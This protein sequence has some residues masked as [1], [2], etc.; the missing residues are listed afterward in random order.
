MYKSPLNYVGNKYRLLPQLLKLFPKNINNFIDLFSGGCDVTINTSAKNK[1]A[2]DINFPVIE[3]LLAFQQTP[4]E[5]T[6]EFIDN[7]IAEF[8]LSKT[9]EDGYLQYREKYNN[10]TYNSPLDLFTLSRFSYN[11]LFRFNKH[12]EFNNAF[13]KNRSSFNDN[14]RNN[15]ILTYP[16]F[17]DINISTIDFRKFNL[18]N[19]NKNDFV[20]IDPPYLIARADYNT[21]KTAGLSW[22]ERDELDLYNILDD[23]TKNKI[24]WGFSN[25]LKHKNKINYMLNDWI[26]NNKYTTYN[27]K[28]NYSKL[29]NKLDRIVD[30]TMEILITNYK[31]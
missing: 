11:Q 27:I 16:S 25:F 2:N 13:G 17:Q 30:P 21:G 9:N 18:Q 7:R 6:L 14:M 15:L 29:T 28:A 20:Y 22:N 4:I 5:K 26:Q 3:I 12:G 19:L 10:G 8:N 23:L 1:Y 24:N 31:M